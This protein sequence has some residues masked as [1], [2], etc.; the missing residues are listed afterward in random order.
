V[1]TKSMIDLDQLSEKRPF[2]YHLTNRENVPSIV[3]ERFIW[4][5]SALLQAA[6]DRAAQRYIREKRPNHIMIRVRG[7][8]VHIRDQ[9]PISEKLLANCLLGGLVLGDY[10]D[11]LNGRVFFWPTLQ[12]L[13]RHYERYEAEGPTIL[14][15]RTQELL[16]LNHVELSRLNS[17]ATRANSYLG[18]IAPPRGRETFQTPDDYG[19]G[20]SSIAE[21]TV[22]DRCALPQNFEHAPSP[23]GPWIQIRR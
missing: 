20:I 6:D 1:E 9:R 5:A 3:R 15:F 19:L 16:D 23:D 18:G 14:R 8:N 4:S 13:R 2:L 17:G 10:Y 22:E 12:R 7:Q 21:V 11:L